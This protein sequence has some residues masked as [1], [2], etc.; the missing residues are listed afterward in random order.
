MKYLSIWIKHKKNLLSEINNLESTLK[1]KIATYNK[2]VD[3]LNED[4]EKL[5]STRPGLDRTNWSVVQDFNNKRDKLIARIDAL[6][7]E[8]NNIQTLQ[9]KYKSLIKSYNSN[10]LVLNDFNNSIDSTLKSPA[11]VSEWYTV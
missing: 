2:D 8:Y 6:G 7:L 3:Q 10:V 11:T 5:E 1:A 4:V 9:D